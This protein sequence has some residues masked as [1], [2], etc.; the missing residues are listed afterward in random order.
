M[1]TSKETKYIAIVDENHCYGKGDCIK[2]CEVK[3]IEEGP[4]RMPMVC[5][6]V[7]LLPGKAIINAEICNGCGDCVDACSYHAITMMLV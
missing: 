4:K 6:A 2:V 3:A 5:G 7:D 1:S